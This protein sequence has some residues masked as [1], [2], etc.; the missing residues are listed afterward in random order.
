MLPDLNLDETGFE[1]MDLDMMFDGTGLFSLEAQ[2]DQVKESIRELTDIAATRKGAKKEPTEEEKA[3]AAADAFDAR[4]KMREGGKADRDAEDTER[5]LV[6]ICGSRAERESLAE[7][8][9]GD[10]DDRY[11]SVAKLQANLKQA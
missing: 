7:R 2:P 8:L 1:P 10:R 4:Q 9:G 11:I 6:V 3:A 5:Y